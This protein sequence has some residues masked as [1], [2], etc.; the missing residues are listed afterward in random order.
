MVHQPRPYPDLFRM[1][2]QVIKKYHV[3]F[4]L[5]KCQFLKDRVEYVGHNLTLTGNVPSKS[6]F[7]MI[8][9]WKFWHV[10]RVYI[11][12]STSYMFLSQLRAILWSAYQT[13]AEIVPRLVL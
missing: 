4:I 3:S 8:N 7:N 12:S 11:I 1:C 10:A 5:D 13:F 6:K 2:M 9:D